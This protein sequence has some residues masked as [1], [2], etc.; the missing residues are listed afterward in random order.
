MSWT[1]YLD[2][3]PVGLGLRAGNYLASLIAPE[4]ARP[5]PR[6]T[7][8]PA[9][10]PRRSAPAPRSRTPAPAPT[11]RRGRAAPAGGTTETYLARWGGKDPAE[12]REI[13]QTARQSVVRGVTDP[14]QRER[15]LSRFDTDPRVQ[16]MRQLAG[17]ERVTT[18]RAELQDVARRAQATREALLDET[19]RRAARERRRR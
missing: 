4:P 13:Y 19:G 18:R 3:T 6:R 5:A 7:P 16:A 1:D 17:L 12:L 10:T 14:A 2:Y 9:P 15:A 11:P 8:T